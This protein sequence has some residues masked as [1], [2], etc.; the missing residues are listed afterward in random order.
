MQLLGSHHCLPANIGSRPIIPACVPRCA[1]AGTAVCIGDLEMQRCASDVFFH[2]LVSIP[3]LEHTLKSM[4]N[5]HS[6]SDNCH[7]CRY[8]H[9]AEAQGRGGGRH[10]LHRGARDGVV[11]RQVSDQPVRGLAGQPKRQGQAGFGSMA[12]SCT[13]RKDSC[14]GVGRQHPGCQ[15][16]YGLP[17]VIEFSMAGLP[18]GQ[19]RLGSARLNDPE[20]PSQRRLLCRNR[21]CRN[22]GCGAVGLAQL[23]SAICAM[24]GQP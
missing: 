10:S 9:R 15:A 4:T 3:C 8:R 5:P 6:A 19:G 18:E 11:C 23:R 17:K 14:A 1:H 24:V 16:V 2:C 13:C 21:C 7:P 20:L 12:S 22:F